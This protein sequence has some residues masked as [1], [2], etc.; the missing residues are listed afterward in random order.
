MD[1]KCNYTGKP[2]PYPMDFDCSG[3]DIYKNAAVKFDNQP[4]YHF[5]EQVELIPKLKKYIFA[6]RG[7]ADRAIDILRDLI[8][9]SGY[10]TL[11]DW[12]DL[13]DISTTIEDHKYRWTKPNIRTNVF[14]TNDG[15]SVE[16]IDLPEYYDDN[17]DSENNDPVNHPAHYTAGG[18]ECIDAIAAALT[19]QNDPMA[20]WLTGQCL[21]YLWRWPLKNGLEDLKK[22]RF[23]LDRL[24]K[25]E[26]EK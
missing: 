7:K 5:S 23:Y 18:I 19:S 22:T 15:Y 4:D 6:S 13:C 26:E 14:P 3:C 2:C 21:K 9:E 11:A 8:N 20:A 17:I 1:I 12:N 10:A 16:F 25:Y 24:I